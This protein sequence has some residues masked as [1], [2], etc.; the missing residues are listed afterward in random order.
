M[1]KLMLIIVLLFS[2]VGLSQNNSEPDEVN[3]TKEYQRIY[4]KG[5]T[6]LHFD[7]QNEEGIISS[8][9]KNYKVS[10]DYNKIESQLASGI[11]EWALILNTGKIESKLSTYCDSKI[12]RVSPNLYIAKYRIKEEIKTRS[13]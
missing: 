8:L 13:L 10:R 11:D 2:F 5:N 3:Y 9:E 1:K 6:K 4:F 7:T 12:T